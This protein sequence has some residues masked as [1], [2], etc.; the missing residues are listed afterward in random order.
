MKNKVAQFLNN[1]CSYK[2]NN[3]CIDESKLST[4]NFSTF[5]DTVK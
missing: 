5:N 4:L 3:L 2:V 1:W